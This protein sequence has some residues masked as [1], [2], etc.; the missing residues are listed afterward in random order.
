MPQPLANGDRR[1]SAPDWFAL[2]GI[3][4]T[5]ALH[6]VLQAKKPSPAFIIGACVFW[7]GFVVVRVFRDPGAFRRW[8]FRSDNLLRASM[9][10]AVLLAAGVVALGAYACWQGHFWLPLHVILL[11]LLYP[12]WGLTQQFLALGIA[13]QNLELV[14]ALGRQKWLLT[15]LGAA[16]FGAIHAPDLWVVAATF[17]LELVLVPLYLRYRN[18]WPLGIL[19]GWLG[20]LFYVWGLGRDVFAESFGRQLRSAGLDPVTER[21]I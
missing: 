17:L 11:F 14:P 9:V 12:L 3:A 1:P 5:I 15:L 7:A 19:H 10:P 13:V 21:P 20:V 2:A 16:L 18:L 6:L 4:V 8:G